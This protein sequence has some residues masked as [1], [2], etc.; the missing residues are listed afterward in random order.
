MGDVIGFGLA[1]EIVGHGHAGDGLK[2]WFGNVGGRGEVGVGD[3]AGEGDEGEDFEVGEPAEAGYVL[4]LWKC[5]RD[6]LI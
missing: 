2:L 6:C 4:V 5:Q 1:E 3:G